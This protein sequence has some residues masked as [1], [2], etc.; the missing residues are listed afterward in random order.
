MPVKSVKGLTIRLMSGDATPVEKTGATLVSISKADPAVVEVDDVSGISAGDP[1]YIEGTG[2]DSIDGQWF[3]VGNVVT[4]AKTFEL[5][6]SDTTADTGTFSA[7]GKVSL[8][9]K[10]G[11]MEKLCLSDVDMSAGSPSEIDIG[12]FCNPGA[13]LPGNAPAGTATFSGY[14]DITDDG[15]KELLV[16]EADRKERLLYIEIPGNGVLVAPVVIGSVSW[17]VPREGST[18]YSFSATMTKR[19]E[20]RF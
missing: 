6:G 9:T 12:T 5:V 19:M 11:M 2:L 7:N 1:V 17:T 8:Y 14:T 10:T 3:T 18:A 13:T 16:A 4:A 20:H 15:Y